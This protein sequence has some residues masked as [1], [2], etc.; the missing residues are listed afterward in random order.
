MKNNRLIPLLLFA[1]VFCVSQFAQPYSL[2]QLENSGLFL[3]TP[4]WLRE[5]MDGKYP[6]SEFV[7]SFL[8]QF[9]DIPVVGGLITAA[10]IALVYWAADRILSRL[11][12][13]F[14]R[15]VSLLA[16][17]ICWVFTAGLDSNLPAVRIML[18][19]V[20]AALVFSLIKPRP[21]KPA[22]R[23]E[24]PAAL[25]LV[26]AAVLFVVT[27]SGIKDTE[28]LAKVQVNARRH[29]W[30]KV[31]EAA[32]PEASASDPRLM[33]YAFLALG[34]KGELGD[35][36]FKYPLSGPE[37][38]DMEGDNSLTGCLFN[39]LLAESLGVPNEAIHHIFQYSCHL[40]HGMSHLT[41]YQLMRYNALKGDYT[42]VRKYAGILRHN[43]K[44]RSA[45]RG[46]LSRYAS[47]A[48][49]ADTLGHSSAGARMVTNNP[50]YNLAQM[51]LLGLGSGISINRFLCYQL[52]IGD[53]DGFR[54]SFEAL[55]FSAGS[56]PVHYQEALLLAGADPSSIGVSEERLKRFSAFISAMSN[57]DDDAV[58]SAARG[59]YWEYYLNV[60]D[61]EFRGDD[62]DLSY[63]SS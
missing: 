57:L 61:R 49:V 19:A 5:V 4:D 11:G 21:E 12:L 38:F 43:P 62:S 31:L 25:V 33:P 22:K 16:A 50:Q 45:A 28:R 1:A 42:M 8:V 37:D 3:L 17:L 39:S 54:S 13:P 9:Y 48:D 15:L 46:I 36:L 63:P 23:W 35:R 40:P 56:V 52:L 14:H 34:E 59:T 53:L 58:R 18:A 7:G 41:L 47:T 10:V 55:G 24:I 2:I 51:S 32:T 29:R 44:N 6:L 20:I 30:D 26:L 27:D 60:Q